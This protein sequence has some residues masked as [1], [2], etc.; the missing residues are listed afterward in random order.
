MR[1]T[2]G[3]NI[4]TAAALALAGCTGEA[5]A[6]DAPPG[7]GAESAVLAAGPEAVIT[8]LAADEIP[9]EARAA[10]LARV[11]GMVFAGAE[12]KER[13]GMVFYDVEGTRPDGSEVELD[14]LVENGA[15]RVVEIQRDLA[16][17][18]VPATARA[19]AEAAPDMFAPVRVIESQQEDGAVIYELFREGQPRE[20]AAEIK[21]VDGKAEM[22][23]ERWAY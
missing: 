7:E 3:L 17:A 5:P 21:L 12:R 15:F 23:T 4:L 1:I 13:D 8:E 22:L 18:D 2:L 10:A 6:D 19:V 16:W 14:M 20:P 11:P 9:E